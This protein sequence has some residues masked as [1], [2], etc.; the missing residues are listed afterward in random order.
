MPGRHHPRSTIEDR[1]EV[2]R[3]SQFG[4]AG[5]D[6]HPHRQLQLPLGRHGSI[7]RCPRRRECRTNPVTGVL[8]HE[9]AV[10]LD[11]RAQHFVMHQ[12]GRPHCVRICFPPTGRTLHIGEQKRHQ[13]RRAD[14]LRRHGI[15]SAQ[16]I[17][18]SKPS[19]L[20]MLQ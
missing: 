10:R 17:C 2:I 4:F 20:A 12:K 19:D 16:A 15:A 8:E 11:R 5:R 7:D 18:P 9:A 13:P 14:G 1:T 6:A 3:P